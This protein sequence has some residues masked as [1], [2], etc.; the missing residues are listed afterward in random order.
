MRSFGA[1]FYDGNI[2][3]DPDTVCANLDFAYLN[4]GQGIVPDEK[5]KEYSAMF[6]ARGKPRGPY[7]VYDPSVPITLQY[8]FI[9]STMDMDSELPLAIDCEL[10][11]D[12]KSAVNY[13]DD[14]S[15]LLGW[16]TRD[17]GYKPHVYTGLWWWQPNMYQWGKGVAGYP[18]WQSE[19]DFALAEYPYAKGRV[20]VS[21][22]E[23]KTKYLP[24]YSTP[25][26][27][28]GITTSQVAWW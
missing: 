14:M 13:W 16:L 19:F 3:K 24:T 22:E 17:L 4:M 15:N 5:Y 12:G 27:S 9:M 21:W 8:K 18:T 6:K 23:M 25:K 7:F 10:A 26:V 28:C 2:I 11:R 20:H 1:D